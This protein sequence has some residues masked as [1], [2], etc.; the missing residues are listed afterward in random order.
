MVDY[1]REE[2][3]GKTPID[4]GI[5]TK[6]IREKFVQ[7]IRE[8][9]EVKNYEAPFI[10]SKGIIKQGL[11]STRKI[12]FNGQTC[13]I[14]I[15]TDVTELRKLENEISHLDRLYLVGEL[16]ASLAHEIRN[17]LAV[18]R[19]FLQLMQ[20]KK[21]YNFRWLK[22]KIEL[23]I[24]ELDRAN[25]IITEFLTLANGKSLNYRFMDLNT[26]INSLL[27]LLEAN[28]IM[29]D[30]NVNTM[31][32]NVPGLRVD[33]N[34][35]RQLIL[36][37]VRNALEATAPNKAVTIR[38]FIEGNEVILAIQDQGCGIAPDIIDKLGTPFITTK[39]NGVGIGLTICKNIVDRHRAKLDLLSSPDGTTACVRFPT[40]D[41]PK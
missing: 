34:E 24:S 6:E 30:K 22:N 27:P 10:T 38:T 28:A 32:E 8:N 29:A 5:W 16:A 36:N 12:N 1:S 31:L 37:L 15:V 4:L 23:M 7:L 21:E 25:T 19:G 17:P 9:G 18:V 40:P 20:I 41:Y 11:I 13:L 33:E 35:I 39:D 3:L 14:S 2:A 26:V